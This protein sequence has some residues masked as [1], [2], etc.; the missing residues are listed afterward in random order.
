MQKD[1]VAGGDD[2]V[3][4]PTKSPYGDWWGEG[5]LTFVGVLVEDVFVGG[6]DNVLYE[7]WVWVG[8]SRYPTN[9]LWALGG[10]NDDG[11]LCEDCARSCVMSITHHSM[12]FLR[13]AP[14]L[15]VH[16][17]TTGRH[18]ARADS[19]YIQS[20]WIYPSET[21]KMRNTPCPTL[22]KPETSRS[23]SS[24]DCFCALSHPLSQLSLPMDEH[25]QIYECDF[26][27]LQFST[28]GIFGSL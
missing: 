4:S 3:V 15:Q 26:L 19:L 27:F 13:C 9:R 14:F 17:R 8:A 1:A 28:G 25:Q 2:V 6:H 12:Q 5:R 20:P 23:S 7:D 11:V 16:L 24:T 10:A 18:D 22:Q 21:L